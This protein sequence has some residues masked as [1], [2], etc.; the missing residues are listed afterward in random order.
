VR[1]PSRQAPRG[2]A[3][4]ASRSGGLPDASPQQRM[5]EV[6]VVVSRLSRVDEPFDD[7][8]EAIRMVAKRWVP[9]VFED[10]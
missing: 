6:L 1:A 9:E 3:S 5:Q 10:V 2:A 4:A 8:D 7:F